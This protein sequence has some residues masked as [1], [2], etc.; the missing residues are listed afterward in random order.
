MTFYATGRR[1]KQGFEFRSLWEKDTK[2]R[3]E[4][5]RNSP[6]WSFDHTFAVSN[7]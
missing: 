5:I 3:P 7:T 2:S 4:Q 1:L 6:I